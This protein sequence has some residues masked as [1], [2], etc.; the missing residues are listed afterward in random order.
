MQPDS[1]SCGS[2]N[3]SCDRPPNLNIKLKIIVMV[4]RELNIV[5]ID[6]IS[7]ELY[8]FTIHYTTTKTDLEKSGILRKL[9]S[10]QNL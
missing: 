5:H 8:R 4:M 6:E 2:R 9:R 3:R 10:Q 7:D 1:G